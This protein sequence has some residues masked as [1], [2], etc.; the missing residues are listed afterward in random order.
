VAAAILAPQD[1]QEL[2]D[3]VVEHAWLLD[4]ARWHD[5]ADLYLEDGILTL[6]GHTL[7][8]RA[9]FLAWAD[10]RAANADR[11]THHQCTNIRLASDGTG[12]AVGTVMLVLFV[13][14]GG[15]PHVEF[16]GEYRDNYERDD[17]G[18]W[19]FRARSLRRLAAPT[20]DI[21]HEGE[22]HA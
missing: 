16:V 2:L 14:D 17:A 4:H 11:H 18:Q 22:R 9:Q 21:P 10:K 8:G 3:L 6:D 20:D 15:A 5:V 12:C 13:S 19:R 1:R 7:T